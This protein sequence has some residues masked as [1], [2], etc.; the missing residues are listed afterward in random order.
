MV[1]LPDRPGG[2]ISR[3]VVGGAVGHAMV[4]NVMVVVMR[5]DRFG[6]MSRGP[7]GQVGQR[8]EAA[9]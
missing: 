5:I 2:V 4:A 8:M 7:V 6:K 1:L 9:A 3:Q